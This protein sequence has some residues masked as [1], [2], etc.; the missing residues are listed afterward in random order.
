MNRIFVALMFGLLLCG[1]A[2]AA[3]VPSVVLHGILDGKQVPGGTGDADGR[4]WLTLVVPGNGSPVAWSAHLTNVALPAVLELRARPHEPSLGG[5]VVL[6]TV[7]V[8]SS[9]QSGTFTTSRDGFL[10]SQPQRIVAL[11]KNAAFAGGAVYGKLSSQGTPGVYTLPVVGRV[12]GLGGTAFVTDLRLTSLDKDWATDNVTVT[13]EWWPGG[14][15]STAPAQTIVKTL[16][17][18]AMLVLNDVM[19][20]ELGLSQALG[21]MRVL[22]SRPIHVTARIYNDQVAAGKGTFGQFT[23]GATPDLGN[24][25]YGGLS[26]LHNVPASTGGFRTNIGWFN[27][28]AVP[29]VILVSV[30]RPNGTHAGSWAGQIGPGIQQQLSINDI[31]PAAASIGDFY[32]VYELTFADSATPGPMDF[33]V[34]AAVTDN[35]NGDAIFVLGQPR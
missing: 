10:A 15:T 27:H 18:G 14:T 24:A 26:H 20:T 9:P 1:T 30:Y 35:V 28:N 6:G 16:S 33:Y 13:I 21:A 19:R 8:T 2:F 22:S 34:Y 5:D 7:T 12:Q 31:V 11:F 25:R 29:V 32:V 23:R 17:A 3:D 4:A